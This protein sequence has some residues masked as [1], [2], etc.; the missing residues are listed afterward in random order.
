MGGNYGYYGKRLINVIKELEKSGILD[1]IYIQKG[2]EYHI[3]DGFLI[4]YNELV[5]IRFR[6]DGYFIA[7]ERNNFI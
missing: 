3:L 7:I 5:C 4:I 1:V 6:Y 2:G